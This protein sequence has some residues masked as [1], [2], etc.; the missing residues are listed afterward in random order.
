MADIK[1]LETLLS[2]LRLFIRAVNRRLDT[3]NNSLAKDLLLTPYSIGGKIIMSQVAIARDLGILSRLDSGDLDNEG[4]NYRKE[5][6]PG[7]FSVVTLTFYSATAPII[8]IVIPA[9]IQAQTAGT[10]FASPVSYSTVAEARF[11]VADAAAYFSYD[12]NRYEFEVTSLCDDI[13]TGGNVGS[14]LINQMVGAIDGIDGITNLIAA[15]G[16]L[17]EE[18]DDDFRKRIQL[19]S[20]GRDLN[21]VNGLSLYMRDLGFIDAYPVRAENV[22]SERATGIDVFVINSSSTAETEIFEYD[23]AQSRYYLTSRPA[24]EV[25]SVVGSNK[26]ALGASDYDTNID[27]SSPLRRSI[28]GQDYIRIRTAAALLTGEQITVT[29]NYASLVVNTQSSL[30]LNSNDVL[31]ADPLV[32][33]AYPLFLYIVASLALKANADG[34]TV[35]NKVRNALSQYSSAYRLGGDLQKSDLIVVMQE[36]YGDYPVENVDAV[37]ISSY[38][39]R[40][41]F[42]I[43]HQPVNEVISVNDKQYIVYG[44]T[45]IT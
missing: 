7:S 37:I 15:T 16:G 33:R 35:R 23:P 27:N 32:K 40:D 12:R 2:E 10:T 42:G 26:G 41:E 6:L 21:T 38:Y 44:S 3:G 18:G 43:T 1:S 17:D 30:N 19:A 45:T 28:Y 8:D 4:T 36:G 31:T 24:L 5:R 29:Y 13:G 22:D 34:P 14:E 25:T 39:L 9:G 20:T 11:I